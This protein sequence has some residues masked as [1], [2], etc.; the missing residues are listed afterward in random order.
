MS[1]ETTHPTFRS[2]ELNDPRLRP[3]EEA[4]PETR[5]MELGLMPLWVSRELGISEPFARIHKVRMG[6]SELLREEDGYD[7]DR[8]QEIAIAAESL[9]YRAIRGLDE[10]SPEE[11]VA[12]ESQRLA[13]T[14]RLGDRVINAW[15]PRVGTGRLVYDLEYG[16]EYG[17]R[18]PEALLDAAASYP[19]PNR[20]ENSPAYQVGTG[21][22]LNTM[23]LAAILANPGLDDASH[24]SVITTQRHLSM[25]DEEVQYARAQ[26]PL[27]VRQWKE[28]AETYQ[29]QELIRAARRPRWWAHH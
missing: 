15:V 19:L 29:T 16:R 28:E 2:S 22:R 10:R 13:W 21:W 5:A 9:R 11:R 24:E 26:A 14:A 27:L 23:Q 3:L 25:S 18:P 12:A 8:E 4:D 1:H 17:I 20:R 7:F 6:D